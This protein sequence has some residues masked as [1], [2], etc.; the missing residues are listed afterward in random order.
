M[1]SIW[2]TLDRRCVVWCVV[3][4]TSVSAELTSLPQFD[5]YHA[6]LAAEKAAAAAAAQAQDNTAGA[7]TGHRRKLRRVQI[8]SDDEE[9]PLQPAH[10]NADYECNL[11]LNAVNDSSESATNYWGVC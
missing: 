4:F 6:R 2:S 1:K 7:S 8:D 11:Y 10:S 9:E 5:E 3:L